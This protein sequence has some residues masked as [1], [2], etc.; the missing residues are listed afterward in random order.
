MTAR[1]LLNLGIIKE[2][3]DVVAPITEKMG[4]SKEFYQKYDEIID[5]MADLSKN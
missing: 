3:T 4:E 2:G 5:A 1:T